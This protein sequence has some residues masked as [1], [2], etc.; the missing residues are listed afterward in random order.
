MVFVACSL[1]AC[2]ESESCGLWDLPPDAYEPD[3]TLE[4]AST[5]APG[6][7]QTR[8]THCERG[9]LDLDYVVLESTPGTVYQ[10]PLVEVTDNGATPNIAIYG[11]DGAALDNFVRWE[12][13]MWL[14]PDEGTYTIEISSGG[15]KPLF[16][17]YELQPASFELSFEIVPGDMYEPDDSL[18][19]ASPSV[20][21]ELREHSLTY[22]GDVDHILF[23]ALAGQ[24]IV[25]FTTEVHPDI[26]TVIT[27]LD[28]Y[29]QELSSAG[30]SWDPSSGGAWTA[31]V[32][33][34]YI[35]R[36]AND[37]TISDFVGPKSYKLSI[38]G[39]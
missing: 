34:D 15:D 9:Q 7:V 1:C 37:A 25:V 21:G 31:L 8:T 32:D 11:P 35:L 5:L 17:D 14:A 28:M 18:A 39:S 20:D 26:A 24:S 38:M 29:G 16:G 36:V 2:G 13:G 19:T 30:P 33:D 27:V 10:A 3:D 4:S 23:S 6:E 12:N 22:F